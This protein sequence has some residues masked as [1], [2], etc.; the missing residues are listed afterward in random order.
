MSWIILGIISQIMPAALL[1][2]HFQYWFPSQKSSIVVESQVRLFNNP[3]DMSPGTIEKGLSTFLTKTKLLFGQKFGWTRLPT[4]HLVRW[5]IFDLVGLLKVIL[6]IERVHSKDQF[7]LEARESYWIKQYPS[8]KTRPVNQIDHCLNVAPYCIVCHN[9][10]VFSCTI[11]SYYSL[12][13]L[14]SRF[15]VWFGWVWV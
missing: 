3:A 7:V 11:Y 14:R 13:I 5:N 9:Y 4:W 12:E 6:P 15:N 2:K 8:V 1:V 10:T